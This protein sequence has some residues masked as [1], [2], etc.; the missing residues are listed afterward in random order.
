MSKIENLARSIAEPFLAEND[1]RLWD[2]V[3][4]KEG[5]M[6]YL[7]ILFERQDGSI[8]MEL[9][10]KLT[11]PLNNLMDE[12]DF[13]KQVDILEIGSPGITRRVRHK[14][15]FD[16]CIGKQIKAMKRLDN[17][18]TEVIT[19]ILSAYDEV[20]K[21]ITLSLQEN[22]Q[23]ISQEILLKKCLRVTLEETQQ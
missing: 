19:G 7:R 21:T 2:V 3:F 22:S 13:I 16:F 8:D 6:H 20:N 17:G 23:E 9:C 5:A 4:E 10:E 15:H 14:E 1:C 18:K 11:R 12:Q